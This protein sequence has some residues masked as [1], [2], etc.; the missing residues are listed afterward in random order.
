[1]RFTGNIYNS[2]GFHQIRFSSFFENR[3]KTI[4]DSRHFCTML[5]LAFLN[6]WNFQIISDLFLVFYSY[7]KSSNFVFCLHTNFE[8]Y[9]VVIQKYYFQFKFIETS[10]NVLRLEWFFDC[11]YSSPC[12]N[13]AFPTSCLHQCPTLLTMRR[14]SVIFF[15]ID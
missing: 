1:M 14:M 12:R 13:N 5:T 7:L 2:Y 11:D 8:I 10:L 15:L 4:V 9:F 3:L 6:V